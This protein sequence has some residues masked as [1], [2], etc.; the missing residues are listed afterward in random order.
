MLPVLLFQE[1]VEQQIAVIDQQI[2]RFGR[3]FMILACNTFEFLA[4]I[5]EDKGDWLCVV[6]A[7]GQWCPVV[8]KNQDP[9]IAARQ[10]R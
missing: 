3:D 7:R 2:R 1:T 10:S 4:G 5:V 6:I 9:V 8:G